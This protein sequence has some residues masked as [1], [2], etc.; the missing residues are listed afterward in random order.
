MK[1]K[2]KGVLRSMSSEELTKHVRVLET[3][4][5]VAKLE[6][7]TKP[8]KNIRLLRSKRLIVAISQT[9]LRERALTLV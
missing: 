3:E 2:E 7:V 4:M 8:S 5:R 9:I 6:R 1:K